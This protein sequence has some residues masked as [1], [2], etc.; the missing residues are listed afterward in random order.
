MTSARC[1]RWRAY[2]T[3]TSRRRLY[4]ERYFTS[5]THDDI[6]SVT[7]AYDDDADASVLGTAWY[8]LTTS[9]GMIGLINSMVGGLLVAVI[10]L[11]LGVGGGL[12]IAFGIAAT[13]VIFVLSVALVARAIPK[14]QARLVTLSRR[15]A[16]NAVGARG[17]HRPMNW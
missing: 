3:P 12:A 11:V 9:A 10:A 13:I 6:L 8:A 14:H 7:M 16:I 17:G 5:A 4:L 1:M 2:A 15:S